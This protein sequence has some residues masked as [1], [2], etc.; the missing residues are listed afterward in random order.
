M[1]L[2][3][4]VYLHL[5]LKKQVNLCRDVLWGKNRGKKAMANPIERYHSS[6]FNS[7]YPFRVPLMRLPEVTEH[8]SFCKRKQSGC[9]C[10]ASKHIVFL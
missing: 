1:L 3:E 9:N 7:Q 10:T 8:I 5:Q 4:F 6:P 2:I